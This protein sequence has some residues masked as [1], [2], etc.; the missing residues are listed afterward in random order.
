[1]GV[2]RL[3][4]IALAAIVIAIG[5]GCGGGDGDGGEETPATTTTQAP[6][7][8]ATATSVGMDEYNFAPE[9]V[10]VSEGDT[11]DVENNGKIVHNL[12]VE[13]GPDPKKES[14]EL[15][16]TSTFGPGKSEKLEIDLKP[17][18]YAMVCTVAGH[19][20]LGMTGTFTVK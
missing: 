1:M 20:E 11:L 4:A 8:A 16:G 14:D 18:K 2:S 10:V 7:S 12:T 17:G 9:D 3:L 19:R 13:K 5:T 15:A 6:D